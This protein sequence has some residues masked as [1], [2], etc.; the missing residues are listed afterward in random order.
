MGEARRR[1]AYE[2]RKANPTRVEAKPAYVRAYWFWKSSQDG[3]YMRIETLLNKA[4]N[5][6]LRGKEL[7]A[8]SFEVRARRMMA[9]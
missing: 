3:T 4:N 2:Q 9:K 6:R 5:L 7:I 1:G 8:Q